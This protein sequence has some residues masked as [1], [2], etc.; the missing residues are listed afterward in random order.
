MSILCLSYTLSSLLS[1]PSSFPPAL[2]S[3][4]S[5]S[6]YQ[7][8]LTFPPSLSST[9][10]P[11]PH[12][13]PTHHASV[14][15]LFTPQMTP[16]LSPHATHHSQTTPPPPSMAAAPLTSYLG[17]LPTSLFS[18]FSPP[19]TTQVYPSQSYLG[20]QQQREHGSVSYDDV[21]PTHTPPPQPPE[22]QFSMPPGVV[23][24]AGM[25][26]QQPSPFQF[27]IKRDPSSE[28]LHSPR[29]DFL[30]PSNVSSNPSHIPLTTDS[31][32]NP[33]MISDMSQSNFS[34]M[35][36]SGQP[37]SSVTMD[38]R[39]TSLLSQQLPTETPPT[40]GSLQHSMGGASGSIA[41]PTGQQIPYRR[42]PTA[43]GPGINEEGAGIVGSKRKEAALQGAPGSK[44]RSPFNSQNDL[45]LWT[46]LQSEEVFSASPLMPPPSVTPSARR[47]SV[48][49]SSQLSERPVLQKNKSEPPGSLLLKVMTTNMLLCAVCM[50]I[51]VYMYTTMQIRNNLV[52][53]KSILLKGSN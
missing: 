44:R 15:Q 14:Q 38:T 16:S 23:G 37:M 36:L 34:N 39:Q 7:P 41:T 6:S 19:S 31:D 2:L 17:E 11:L 42:L 47:A 48:G 28:S 40:F 3:R 26:L 12:A 21:T 25:G 1:L 45:P 18:P 32:Y 29:G 43:V 49:S 52:Y 10:P 50:Y 33:S 13:H 51:H 46:S 24:G 53:S 5:S 20:P 22:A 4:T 30:S 9:A 27:P 8:P 35:L